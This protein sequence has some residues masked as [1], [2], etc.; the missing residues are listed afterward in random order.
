MNQHQTTTSSSVREL[1]NDND[2][3]IALCTYVDPTYTT[4]SKFPNVLILTPSFRAD[5]SHTG[6]TRKKCTLCNT[7][8]PITLLFGGVRTDMPRKGKEFET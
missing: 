7:V 4:D 6:Y 5:T 2:D 3:Q 1:I 8:G